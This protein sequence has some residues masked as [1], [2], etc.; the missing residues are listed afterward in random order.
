MDI[1]YKA[2]I[3]YQVEIEPYEYI[4]YVTDKNNQINE[5]FD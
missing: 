3:Q 4:F 5:A 1:T 2:L